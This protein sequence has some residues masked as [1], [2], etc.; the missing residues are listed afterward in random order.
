MDEWRG[1]WGVGRVSKGMV[2][3]GLCYAPLRLNY[4]S[5]YFYTMECILNKTLFLARVM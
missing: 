4:V 2:P 3:V 1:R 5:A